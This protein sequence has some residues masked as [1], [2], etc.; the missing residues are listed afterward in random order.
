MVSNVPNIHLG[1]YKNYQNFHPLIFYGKTRLRGV[2]ADL[3]PLGENG[4]TRK[5]KKTKTNSSIY[6]TAEALVIVAVSEV[7]TIPSH[8][9]CGFHTIPALNSC[10]PKS[11]ISL[12]ISPNPVF[13]GP[14]SDHW[15]CLSLTNWLTHSVAFSKLD[16]CNHDVRRC[17]LMLM[18]RIVSATVCCR[19][20]S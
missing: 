6:C 7:W 4:L 20:W 1:I 15:E 13:I 11:H 18:M 16:W 3:P 5:P 14:E 19:F 2:Q 10:D 17:L 12:T 8:P 9:Q